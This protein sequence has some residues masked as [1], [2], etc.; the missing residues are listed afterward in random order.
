MNEQET[1]TCKICGKTMSRDMMGRYQNICERCC[2]FAED[3]MPGVDYD[4][5]LDE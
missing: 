2:S 3:T 4:D 1:F 5:C